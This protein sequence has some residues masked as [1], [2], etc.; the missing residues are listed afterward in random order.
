MAWRRAGDK[1]L[2][3]PMYSLVRN[4]HASLSPWL[5]IH[6]VTNARVLYSIWNKTSTTMEFNQ[7]DQ[8]KT[9]YREYTRHFESPTACKLVVVITSP[10]RIKPYIYIQIS[11]QQQL[12]A[13]L[14]LADIREEWVSLVSH[15]YTQII[16]QKSEIRWRNIDK[17]MA[18]QTAKSKGYEK[19]T[20]CLLTTI[21]TPC[22]LV[23]TYG[24]REPGQHW[25][26]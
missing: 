9:M 6:A 10:F 25:L 5:Y 21:L 1:P 8:L 24:D 15:T 22:D 2:S 23:T 4:L 18:H 26:R 11:G 16:I 3:E 13:I 12:Q 19:K 14:K 17:K 20:I 7:V